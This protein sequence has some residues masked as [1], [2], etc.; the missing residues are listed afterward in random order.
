MAVGSVLSVLMMI[1]FLFGVERIIWEMTS[2]ALFDW[3]I[4]LEIDK[5]KIVVNWTRTKFCT[6]SETK[7]CYEMEKRIALLSLNHPPKFPFFSAAPIYFASA[8]IA[9]AKHKTV[10]LHMKYTLSI[11]N[12]INDWL[13]FWN[14]K[15]IEIGKK[16]YWWSK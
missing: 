3:M 13:M 14:R 11:V 4:M 10:D 16:C 5:S 8:G 12:K 2:R 1:F 9:L 15:R 6:T 7:V